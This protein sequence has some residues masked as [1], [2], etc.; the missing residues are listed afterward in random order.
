MCVFHSRCSWSI[1]PKY[2]TIVHG[3]TF[4][5]IIRKL[6]CL[7]ILLFFARKIIISVL[8]VLRLIVFALNYS[9][10][11]FLSDL[12]AKRRSVLSAKCRALLCMAAQCRSF[13]KIINNSGPRTDRCGTPW[14]IL[15]SSEF[16][17]SNEVNCCLL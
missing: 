13:I 2:F 16:Y 15:L 8:V 17:P 1:T 14:E 6:R 10:S 11:V 3:F 4:C 5:P 12:F 7:V 9:F